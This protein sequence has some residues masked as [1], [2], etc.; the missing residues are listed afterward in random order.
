M[1]LT[2]LA[3]DL[4]GRWHTYALL[5]FMAGIVAHI[6]EHLTQAIQ[7][8]A[9]GWET[10]DSRGILG[11][12]WPWLATSETLHYF[13]AVFTLFGIVLLL[14]AFRGTARFFWYAALGFQ[15]WHHLEHLILIYQRQ[16]GDFWFGR[17]V[18]TGFGQ[19]LIDRV[20]LHD[21]YNLLVFV[22]MLLALYYH[23]RSDQDG[24]AICGCAR[25]RPRVVQAGLRVTS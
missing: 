9:L 16:A 7:I 1:Q 3:I 8:Y 5:F 17:G 14:P 22:P 25:W 11:Q 23:F 20:A 19:L 2:K 6:S 24:D 13:Y 10:P 21:V 15:F 12:W 4:N 18:P